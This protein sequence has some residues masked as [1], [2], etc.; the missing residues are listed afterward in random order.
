VR[1]H[2][3]WFAALLVT[4]ALV[5]GLAAGIGGYLERQT[6]T[7]VRASLAERA[8]AHLALRVGLP[9]A[10]DAREQDAQ[11]RG[12]IERRFAEYPAGVAV[13]RTVV[14]EL[15]YAD[16]DGILGPV[17]GM[18]LEDPEGSLTLVEGAWAGSGE[19]IVHAH[20]ATDLGLQTG[21]RISIGETAFTISGT[22]LPRDHLDPRWLGD[23]LVESGRSETA[24]GPF[25]VAESV[26]PLAEHVP[27]A[28]WTLEPDLAAAG[29]RDL[30]VLA[31]AWTGLHRGWEGEEGGL[32]GLA[33][34]G[35]LLQ[36]ISDVEARVAGLHAAQPV[37][38][39]LLA[40]VALVT[41][42][43]LARL[44]TALRATETALLWSR[45]ASPLAIATRSGA[46]A[47]A[48]ALLGAILGVGTAVGVLAM[49]PGP[50]SPP[51]VLLPLAAT[52]ALA[53]LT[54]AGASARSAL[55]QT[56]RDPS[57][58]AGRRRRLAG[59]G[60]VALAVAAAALSVWQL[61]LYGSPV[62]PTA[63]GGSSVDPVAVPAPALTLVAVALAALALF[64]AVA[65]LEELRSARRGVRRL[66]A[67]R[68]VARRPALVAAPLLVVALATGSLVAAAGYEATWGGAFDAAGRL[69]T[70]ADVHVSMDAPGI[71]A[72]VVDDLASAPGVENVAP[73]I[74]Q[75]LQFGS[76]SGT[77]VAVA[78]ATLV[79]SAAVSSD[80]LDSA[81]IAD[82]LKIAPVGPEVPPGSR[83]LRLTTSTEG[84]AVPPSLEAILRDGYG[85]MRAVAFEH[86]ASSPDPNHPS[87]VAS[88]YAAPLPPVL[89]R[90]D[91]EVRV[92]AFDARIPR[93]AV[94]GS[95]A[96]TFRLVSLGAVARGAPVDLPLT[97]V[98]AADS[99]VPAADPPSS[100]DDGLG[101]RVASA[102]ERARLTATLDGGFSDRVQPPIVVSRA[103]AETYGVSVGD[104]LSFSVDG[105]TGQLDAR[106]AAIVPAV[107]TS[108][109]A[110]AA[111]VDLTIVQHYGL[112][113]ADRRNAP[114]DLWIGS[115]DPA[116]TIASLRGM[117]PA[118]SR[119]SAA[120]DP[121]G[122]AILGAASVALWLAAGGCAVLAVAGV[123]AS[124]R[125]LRRER[126]GG[127]AILR[128]L[129]LS[130]RDQAS[131]R[132]RELGS[133]VGY[134]ALAGLVAG[135]AVVALTVAPIARAAVPGIVE[136]LPTVPSLSPAPLVLA[137]GALALA[138]V[139]VVAGSS[140]G[141]A[142]EASTASP[143]GESR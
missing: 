68:T 57:D 51:P 100:H 60:V 47:G 139:A 38:L 19:I 4:S 87:R 71:P 143:T 35:R 8:G 97:G 88:T 2:A 9:L 32:R 20:A 126:R 129:G 48:V 16:A 102:T 124:G 108:P 50:A 45:G 83:E 140:A 133:V 80:A 137:L 82:A 105:A 23:P 77:L 59:G 85:I 132:A 69:R 63:D 49:W 14:G 90:L 41:F 5:A 113:A 28:R 106:I 123:A 79:R 125:S 13:E 54:V 39:L 109:R 95:A 93:E 12:M 128:A 76:G 119:I 11:V 29:T 3:G 84:F 136:R 40:A 120:Q 30:D 114:A 24:T 135:A 122:R 6:A 75:K 1:E 56:V 17:T 31:T 138:L 127:I 7:G 52:T 94:A 65:S 73:A 74:V 96:G 142:R 46:E 99:P 36:T 27:Q 101:F 78:P 89:A 131:I 26:W 64:P 34:G 130:P 115:D 44:L 43:E 18:T 116:A 33:K 72:R 37:A 98:W 134:G 117:L 58:T 67:A 21:E 104:I 25:L 81:A 53:V 66:L 22:W 107:P 103:L 70:G 141:A 61:Q 111:L 42:A 62:T 112:R 92:V 15:R 118:N 86:L 121:A 91:V 10:A 110:I 55:R